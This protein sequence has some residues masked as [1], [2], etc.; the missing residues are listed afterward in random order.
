MTG[1]ATPGETAGGPVARRR[2][3]W[4][5]WAL[6]AVFAAPILAT[7]FYF[8]FPEYLPETRSNRGEI[9]K[10]ALALPEGLDLSTLDGDPFDSA[11]LEGAWTL[12]YLTAGSCDQGCI[13]HLMQIR[14]IRLGLGEGRKLVERLLLIGDLSAPVDQALL[15]DAFAGMGV[16]QIDGGGLAALLGALGSGPEALGRVYLLDPQGRLAMR[17][18]ADA[19][20]KD[21]LKDLERLLKGSK[22][23]IKG[24][25]Y[26]HN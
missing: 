23:W 22:N 15:D 12:V 5:L 3:L 26:G 2:G 24:A 19:P 8:F 17:Y 4:P 9:L 11:S 18:A 7:W 20:P 13:D 25:N 10:P 6:I 1:P 16:A 14:Q 21:I